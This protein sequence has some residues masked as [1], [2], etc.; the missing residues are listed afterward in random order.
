M[1][2][3]TGDAGMPPP[4]RTAAVDTLW[5]MNIPRAAPEPGYR[6]LRYLSVASLIAIV[7][8]VALLGALCRELAVRDLR[9]M[10]ERNNVAL[11]RTF[12]NVL[13]PRY[14]D[15]LSDTAALDAQALRAHPRI[16]PKFQALFAEIMFVPQ[17][18]L[19]RREREMIAA[20]AA[21]AQDCHY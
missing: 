13:W 1:N 16:G 20:V 17:G 19:D 18:A 6:P 14:G 5:S 7:L 10:G 3:A 12:A 21:A 9:E 8:A 4:G 11:T 2:R 15:F